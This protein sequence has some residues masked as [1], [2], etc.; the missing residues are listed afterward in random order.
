MKNE[1]CDTC[2]SKDTEIYPG[3]GLRCYD[4]FP[5]QGAEKELE[6]IKNL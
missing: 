5:W 6:N 4:C 1:L 3:L 2:G